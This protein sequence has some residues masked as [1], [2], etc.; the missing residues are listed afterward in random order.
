[1]AAVF[2]NEFFVPREFFEQN[3]FF[4]R[5]LNKNNFA[6]V[7]KNWIPRVQRNNLRLKK[8]I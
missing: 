4:Y 1:M 7:L 2:E 8:S 5:F 6:G 3:M